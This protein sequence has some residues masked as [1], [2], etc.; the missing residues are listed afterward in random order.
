VRRDVQTAAA[1]MLC[2]LPPA[3]EPGKTAVPA[4]AR[5]GAA[6]LDCLY[7]LTRVQVG[8]AVAV[9]LGSAELLEEPLA[10]PRARRLHSAQPSGDL[11]GSGRVERL[12]SP[13]PEDEGLELCS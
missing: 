10:L 2:S 9:P 1:S 11:M 8:E 6:S 12:A 13:Q 7:L 3:G 4:D 5:I